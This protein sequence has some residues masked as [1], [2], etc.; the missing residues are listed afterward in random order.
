MACALTTGINSTV[1]KD[2]TPGVIRFFITELANI[3]SYTLSAG[4]VTAMDLVAGKQFWIYEQIKESSSWTEELITNVQAG[5]IGFSQTVNIS[6][7]R[8]T[9]EKV[10]EIKLL[11]QNSLVVIV[12]DANNFYSII[13]L[14]RGADL[15]NGSKYDSGIKLGDKNGWDLVFKGSEHD[16]APSVSAAIV[17]RLTHPAS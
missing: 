10:N 1:C 15:D 7:P 14:T 13:G 4:V 8:R 2:G 11:A 12:E 3:E 6:I 9:A 5:S 16:P 17:A